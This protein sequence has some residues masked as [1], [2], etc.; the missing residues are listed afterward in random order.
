[1]TARLSARCAAASRTVCRPDPQSPR[2]S[3]QKPLLGPAGC[4]KSNCGAVRFLR[5]N[6]LIPRRFLPLLL[7]LRFLGSAAAPRRRASGLL[8]HPAPKAHR[9][10]DPHPPPCPKGSMPDRRQS[11]SLTSTSSTTCGDYDRTLS[12]TR[13]SLTGVLCAPYSNR[14]LGGGTDGLDGLLDGRM[15]VFPRLV[16][17]EQDWI[18]SAERA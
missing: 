2:G 3:A 12:S 1:M 10:A 8:Q 4:M 6:R 18:P 14:N 17:A 15:T 13:I 11:R 16:F 9:P 7:E 5:D